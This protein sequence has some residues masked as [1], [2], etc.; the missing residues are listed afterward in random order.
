MTLTPGAG[1]FL[2]WFSG[3]V[4]GSDSGSY[5]RVS[6]YVDGV[7]VPESEREVF[8]ESSII[9]TD[10]NIHTHASVT[11]VGAGQAIEIRWH[12]SG[13]GTATMHER[14]LVVQRAGTGG[15]GA[16]FAAAEDTKLV[17][18]PK[19][20]TRRLRFEVSN[21][22]NAASGATTYQLQVAE[23]AAC[24]TGTYSAVPTD[25]SGH[26]QVVDSTFL[27]DATATTNISPGL[28]DENATFVAGEFKDSGNTT[29]A[30]TLGVDTFTEMEFALQ[31]TANATD[32]ADYC[33]RLYDTASG[34]T[35]DTHTVYGQARLLGA[36]LAISKVDS[37]D[38][39]AV[40]SALNYTLSVSN[41][42]PSTANNLVVTDSLT[43]AVTFVSASGT[44]WSCSWSAPVVTCTRPTLAAGSSAPA[45]TI[46]VTTPGAPTVLNNTAS[47]TA[48][49]PDP[50]PA[51]NSDSEFTTVNFG[52]QVDLSLT[53]ADTV[54]P[55]VVNGTLGYVLT[56]TNNSGIPANNLIVTDSLP[57]D[58][59]FQSAIG[60]GWN[61]SHSGQPTGGV[62]TCTLGSLGQ[63]STAPV[64]NIT[65]TAPGA[66][67]TLNN[68]ASVTGDETDPVGTNNN[69]SEDTTVVEG[70]NADLGITKTDS[71]DPVALGG[72]ISYTLSVE[73][74]GPSAATNVTVVDTLPSPVTFQSAGGTGWSCVPSGLTVTCTRATLAIGVAP[75]ITLSVTAPGSDQVVTNTAAVSADEADPISANNSDFEG[76]TV[77][78]PVAADLGIGMV[79]GPEPVDMSATL[80]YSIRVT[81]Y[82]PATA[83][84]V[85]VTDTLPAGVGFLSAIGTGWACLENA[86]VVTCTRSSLAVGVAPE[87]S[88]TVSTPGYTGTISNSASITTGN[89]AQPDPYLPNNSVSVVSTVR[90]PSTLEDLCWA[91]SDSGDLLVSIGRSAPH[92]VDTV[93]SLGTGA[94]EAITFGPSPSGP[95]LFGADE[96]TASLGTINV[97]TGLYT[98]IGP[99]GTGGGADGELLMADIDGLAFHPQTLELWATFRKGGPDA[100]LKIDYSTG[101]HVPD[102]W[103]PGVD[104]LE[105]DFDGALGG[106][107]CD[108]NDLDDLA[109]SDDGRWFVQVD[110]GGNNQQLGELEIDAS[111][112]PTGRFLSCVDL[113]DVNGLRVEDMEG[114]GFDQNGIMWGTTGSD[115]NNGNDNRLWIIDPATGIATHP[116]T[117]GAPGAPF[118]VG[119]D[120]E[121]SDCRIIDGSGAGDN[122]VEGTVFFDDNADGLLHPT[123][124]GWANATVRIYFDV[125]G[126]GVLDP[127]D[128]L[129]QTTVTD[130][131]GFFGFY[132]LA[133]GP[134]V[135][136]IDA[137][138]LPAST[139]M[140]TDN[141]EMAVFAGLG[142]EDPGN[143]FGFESTT[144]ALISDVVVYADGGVPVVEFTT[145]SEVGTLGFFLARW[146]YDSQDWQILNEDMLP[147]VGAAQGGTYRFADRA[148]PEEEGAYYSITE[149]EASGRERP[150]GPFLARWV[151]AGD[152]EVLETR[153]SAAARQPSAAVTR[154]LE[155]ARVEARRIEEKRAPRTTGP[156]ELGSTSTGTFT[157]QEL[158]LRVREDNLY[159][160]SLVQLQPLFGSRPGF[161]QRALSRGELEL[162]NRGRPVAWWPDPALRGLYFFGE[163][164]QSIFSEDNVYWLRSGDGSVMA[165]VDG[166]PAQGRQGLDFVES[167]HF[168]EQ[169][170]AATLVSEET[171]ADFWYWAVLVGGHPT[172]GSKTA[173]VTLP[174][175]VILESDARLRL[176]V[177]GVTSTSVL[178]E[179]HVEVF[180][181]Q[182][183]IGDAYL[184]GRG[185]E[186]L[187]FLV[188]A[189]VLSGGANQIEVEALLESG[190]TYSVLYLD[191]FDLEY[192]RRLEAHSNR[193]RFR[194]DSSGSVEVSGFSQP[195]LLLFDITDPSQPQRVESA[196][197]QGGFTVRFH[198]ERGA[199]YL[200]LA[201]SQVSLPLDVRVDSPSALLDERGAD[202][203]VIAPEELL[204]GA[205]ELAATREDRGLTTLVID[206]QDIYDELNGG[207]ASPL[208]IRDF[209]REA[210]YEWSIPPRYVALAGA[211]HF[212]YRDY[213]NRGSNL[214]PPLLSGSRPNGLFATDLVMGDVVGD[215]GVPEVA[216][217]RI[218]VLSNQELLDYVD[219]LSAFETRGP[220]S[221][222][223]RPGGRVLLLADRPD[224]VGY[225]SNDS[226][227]LARMVPAGL[228]AER[229]HLSDMEITEARSAL[230]DALDD[231]TLFWVNYFGHGGLD[232]F[233]ADGLLTVADVPELGRGVSIVTALTCVIGRF[234]VPGYPSLAEELVL[235]PDSGAVA[236][237]SPTGLS[238]N[239]QSVRLDEALFRA[240]FRGGAPTLGDAVIEALSEV[241]GQF[242]SPRPFETYNI[243]GDPAL[244]LR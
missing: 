154:R 82:G 73:N 108:E 114:T 164:S 34:S 189:G 212:D 233:S 4:V 58:V 129:L 60:A 174:D 123:E 101:A 70:A 71:V 171:E 81:N 187:E 30:I 160:V 227:G 50:D 37:P 125:A 225:F 63:S 23:T 90:D 166:T 177:T 91:A 184:T 44:G 93:G 228:L 149:V 144:M 54:D 173:E 243:L 176:Q 190:V 159:F 119:G 47:V 86:G 127:T 183:P 107:A 97:N 9:D 115:S 158:R 172:W 28:T 113:V 10:F 206:L 121:G 29:G 57:N 209:V 48:D 3:S 231:P 175:D 32:G 229:I 244:G 185:R 131:N 96:D 201:T 213:G 77:G 226:D 216:I 223:G 74:F 222:Y 42:G 118:G 117:G 22:G 142:F 112:I 161:A 197:V 33:F 224:E 49:E 153:S 2:V 192:R 13:S 75:P 27:A 207:N 8:Q 35:L 180:V 7:K 194:A 135:L 167:R 40:S 181:N 151:D 39:V 126:N 179:H 79:A 139:A 134:Y 219:K 238:I 55:V 83:S 132:L 103:G 88:I 41:N 72:T 205:R 165:E 204:E 100:I 232:R 51:N 186:E 141:L 68:S 130:A 45:I 104:Y 106:A 46:T 169:L 140:T 38:P 143:D 241:S 18:L 122:T 116:S 155:E 220:E 11:G 208:A 211:G 85:I 84:N 145:S 203:V 19:S 191:G 170:F 25:T 182:T 230:F 92:T 235:A 105:M 5:Q 198:A 65:V 102:L 133:G 236:V 89:R 24:S 12:R 200:V 218:P 240:V 99:V 87:I 94:V 147:A 36:D 59:A 124:L 52:S 195:D 163:A 14:T 26:W 156:T 31:A 188:P 95:L 168:E 17:D 6:I 110:S 162:T 56:V 138:T 1:D 137:A 150:H 210:W 202:Y 196:Q 53:K 237:F 199:E 80:L 76:T 214:I 157:E 152:R 69:D 98:P 217:G 146:D 78:T 136:D 193:L 178:K 66:P 64:I 234:E 128:P 148:W 16:T 239:R 20:S 62:V 109:I 120:Y 61:C 15:T 67:T 215:D 111:G 43:A 21:E 221:V 242:S